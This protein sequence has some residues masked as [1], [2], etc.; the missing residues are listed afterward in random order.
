VWIVGCE[1]SQYFSTDNG[2]TW[3]AA[4]IPALDISYGIAAEIPPDEYDIRNYETLV[5]GG[6][7]SVANVPG[8]SGNIDTPPPS[9]NQ[10]GWTPPTPIFMSTDGGRTWIAGRNGVSSPN[11][12]FGNSSDGSANDNIPGG[13]CGI[14][15][16]VAWNGQLWVAVGQAGVNVS[17]STSMGNSIYS[18][19]DGMS[20]SVVSGT[21]FSV[22]GYDVAWGPKGFVA[23]GNDVFGNPVLW[24]YGG[25][26]WQSTIT[27]G[28]FAGGYA[29]SVWSG[30]FGGEQTYIAT[31]FDPTASNNTM[32]TSTD[33][34]TW[35]LVPG[36]FTQL[37]VKVLGGF[38]GTIVAVGDNGAGGTTYTD[39]W[40]WGSPTLSWTD[41]GPTFTTGF[42]GIA[43]NG[44]TLVGVG[45][46][47]LTMFALSST[48]VTIPATSFG[49][50]G[51]SVAWTGSHWIATGTDTKDGLPY[52]LV[53]YDT[54]AIAWV[55]LVPNTCPILGQAYTLRLRN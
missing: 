20:W 35:T 46:G 32:Y 37:G 26:T 27:S 44:E 30:L 39:L 11:V 13:S 7:T 34:Q 1:V 38:G 10:W 40:I 29:T 36:V 14:V 5:I 43:T 28:M 49:Y 15:Y 53:S 55:R 52:T 25:L 45:L 21:T 51:H 2:F 18:S 17:T 6:D 19:A 12:L 31:G 50:A 54:R 4:S 24:S 3:T 9:V 42:N 47:G 41:I 8:A 16:G 23:V 33:G 48:G 22:Q